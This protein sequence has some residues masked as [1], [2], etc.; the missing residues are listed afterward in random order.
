M[1]ARVLLNQWDGSIGGAIEVLDIVLKGTTYFI[2][3]MTNMKMVIGVIGHLT[4]VEQGLLEQGYFS[5]RPS[6]V[7][8]YVAYSLTPF[9]AFDQQDP[10]VGGFDTSSWLNKKQ[11]LK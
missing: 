3:D 4:N 8:E 1:R 2:H 9:F 5:V 6:G 7:K 10:Q 11:I